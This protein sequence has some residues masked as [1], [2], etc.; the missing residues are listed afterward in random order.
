MDQRTY[1]SVVLPLERL[2]CVGAYLNVQSPV[3]FKLK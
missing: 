1:V 2:E 3:N